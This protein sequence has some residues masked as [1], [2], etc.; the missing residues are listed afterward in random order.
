[1]EEILLAHQG[2]VD[3][4][5]IFRTHAWAIAVSSGNYRSEPKPEE[6]YSLPYDDEKEDEI[7]SEDLQAFYDTTIKEWN[8]G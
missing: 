7:P 5:K 1:V 3:E 2:K 4:W 6:L 8:G